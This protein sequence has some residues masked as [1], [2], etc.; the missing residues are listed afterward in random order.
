MEKKESGLKMLLASSQNS[1][2]LSMTIVGAIVLGA[3]Y[4]LPR[5]NIG[6]DQVANIVDA[7]LNISKLVVQVGGMIITTWGALRKILNQIKD[8]YKK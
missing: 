7:I 6:T 3:G 5:A 8:A 1:E 4:L 2:K